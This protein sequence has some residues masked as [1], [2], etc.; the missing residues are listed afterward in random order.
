[1]WLHDTRTPWTHYVV[2]TGPTWTYYVVAWYWATLDT[3][4]NQSQPPLDT[5]Y[6]S[7]LTPLATLC[8]FSQIPLDILISGHYLPPGFFL[9]MSFRGGNCF[10]GER[11]CEK[12]PAA[13]LN[14]L[15]FGGEIQNFGGEIS[16]PKGPEKNTA[17]WRARSPVSSLRSL[18]MHLDPWSLLVLT[19]LVRSSLP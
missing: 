7:S 15:V 8:D 13:R 4:C 3:L 10:C 19:T 11:K 6:D 14:L 9:E 2:G 12:H 18:S 16:P 17:S 5:L 1:M